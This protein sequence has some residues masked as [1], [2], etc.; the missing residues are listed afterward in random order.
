MLVPSAA[1]VKQFVQ[2]NL[3]KLLARVG[4]ALDNILE[5]FCIGTDMLSADRLRQLRMTE[6]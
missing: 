4:A 6:K 5:R 1:V 2:A 3:H